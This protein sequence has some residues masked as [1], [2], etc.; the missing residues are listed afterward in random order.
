LYGVN[1][2]CAETAVVSR[3]TSHATTK[4]RCQLTTSVNIN[5]NKN[6]LQKT[7]QTVIQNQVRH[8]SAREQR[9]ALNEFNAINNYILLLK[10]IQLWNY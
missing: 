8:E 9:I 5:N 4:Q 7:L 10:T 6:A 1:K 3:G 2:T